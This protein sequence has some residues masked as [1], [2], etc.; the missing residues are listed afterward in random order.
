MFAFSVWQLRRTAKPLRLFNFAVL[1]TLILL[2]ALGSVATWL[3]TTDDNLEGCMRNYPTDCRYL[4]YPEGRE[5]R[6]SGEIEMLR[7]LHLSIFAGD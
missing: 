3:Q 1:S 4:I 5:N 6:I 2:F 7:R